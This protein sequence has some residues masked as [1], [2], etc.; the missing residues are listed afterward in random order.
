MK[1]KKQLNLK[2]FQDKKIT[3][4]RMRI[5]LVEKNLR[6]MKSQKNFEYLPKQKKISIKKIRIKSKR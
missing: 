2:K 1:L 5:K 4:K 3:I 6:S